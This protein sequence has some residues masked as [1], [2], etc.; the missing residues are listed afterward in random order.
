MGGAPSRKSIR[1]EELQVAVQFVGKRSRLRFNS[2]GG[3]PIRGE[4][5]QV[6]VRAPIR[7]GEPQ[8]AVQFVGRS[9]NSW[10]KSPRSQFTSWGGAPIRGEEP[11]VTDLCVRDLLV[12]DFSHAG[13]LCDFC[14][15]GD[16]AIFEFVFAV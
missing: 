1:W 5:P 9:S 15:F 11:Q 2:W 12:T 4:E 7:G 13:G 10:G 3:A 6:A 8:V 16:F 14:F